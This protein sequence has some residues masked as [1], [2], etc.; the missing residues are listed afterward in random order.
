MEQSLTDMPA[1][2]TKEKE[3]HH[4]NSGKS[5]TLVIK[6]LDRGRKFKNERYLSADSVYTGLMGLDFIVKAKC[7][8]SMKKEKRE[9]QVSISRISR[10][11]TKA[12]CTCPAGKSSY[13]NHVMALLLELADY[14]LTSVPEEISCT[15]RLSQWVIPGDSSAVK[16]PVIDTVVQKQTSSK[17]IQC[18]FEYE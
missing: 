11:I 6:T 17:G 7:K 2:A 5:Q 18:I 14:S 12:T 1:F 4:Q 13:C 8:T 10:I 3:L 16:A 9:V 15:S